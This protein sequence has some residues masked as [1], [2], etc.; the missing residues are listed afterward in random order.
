MVSRIFVIVV[1]GKI[2]YCYCLCCYY[3]C[4]WYYCKTY[5]SEAAAVLIATS[6]YSYKYYSA[7]IAA[8]DTSSHYTALYDN[9]YSAYIRA[10][11]P[12]L[13]TPIP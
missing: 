3:C 11:S 8:V 2:C 12:P 4:C 13:T 7:A 1:V 9:S 5:Y 10:I 6:P